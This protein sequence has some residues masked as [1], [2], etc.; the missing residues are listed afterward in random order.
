[1]EGCGGYGLYLVVDGT[2]SCRVCCWPGRAEG[3]LGLDGDRGF[4]G[5][6][7]A[8]VDVFLTDTG[9]EA[10]SGRGAIGVKWRMGARGGGGFRIWADGGGGGRARAGRM[11][12]E[13][14]SESED[15]DWGSS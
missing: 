15:I 14:E 4:G 8:L 11:V 9:I 12:G 6:G 5:D 13:S 2:T 1:M 10:G 7:D 3:A